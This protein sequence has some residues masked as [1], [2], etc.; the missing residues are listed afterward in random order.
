MNRSRRV[1]SELYGG[2]VVA[3]CTSTNDVAELLKLVAEPL[4]GRCRGPIQSAVAT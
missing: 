4:D 1:I 2:R 3:P